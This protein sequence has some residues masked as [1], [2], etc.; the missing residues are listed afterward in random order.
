MYFGWGGR[1]RTYECRSQSPMPY[2]LATPQKIFA[3]LLYKKLGI[4]K[5]FWFFFIFLY[6]RKDFIFLSKPMLLNIV[7]FLQ[8]RP[9]DRTILLGRTL[10]WLLYIGVMYYNLLYLGKSIDHTYLFWAFTLNSDQIEIVKYIM[11]GLGIIPLFMGISN[12]CILKKKYVRILQICFWVL[13]F[14]IA[15]SIEESA[16]LDVDILIGI[17]WIFPIIGGITGKCITS[18]CLKYK[19][20]ITKIRV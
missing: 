8:K 12:I 1:V 20:K 11:T 15:G 16:N 14:Y 3:F 17:M 4:V 13:L 2:H 18:K 5:I 10:F 9:S 7:Q 6:Y 19:E